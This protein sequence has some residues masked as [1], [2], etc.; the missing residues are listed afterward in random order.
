MEHIYYIEGEFTLQHNVI[1]TK[2]AN[3][4]IFYEFLGISELF[5]DTTGALVIYIQRS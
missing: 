4:K 1:N 3:A 5:K 2:F